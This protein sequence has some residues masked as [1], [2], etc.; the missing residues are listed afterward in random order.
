[1][2]QL[3]KE[4][5]D[6]LVKN[7]IIPEG[8]PPEQ[9]KFFAEVCQR[10]KLDPF[11]RQIHLIERRE[12]DQYGNWKKSYTIQAGIDGMRAIAQRN[13]KII[14]YRRWVEKRDDD[15][16]GCCEIVS[17]RGKYY[18]ELPFKEYVQTK[19]NGEP[20]IFWKKFP[21]T[22]IKKCAEESVLRMMTPEDLSGIYGDDE[23]MQADSE[24]PM[25]QIQLP[26]KELLPQ[27][28][29]LPPVDSEPVETEVKAPKKPNKDKAKKTAKKNEKDIGSEIENAKT[30]NEL[31]SI[32]ESLNEDER[33]IY[34]NKFT[35]RKEEIKTQLENKAKAKADNTILLKIRKATTVEELKKIWSELDEE[36][37]KI[38]IT[39]IT[40]QN[41]ILT[42]NEK[43]D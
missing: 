32:W 6:L 8:T 25:A 22:M 35:E 2:E 4:Q 24:M 26:K 40:E 20:V 27:K 5:I 14:S 38:Y 34:L 3:T 31:K 37:Q 36:H 13:A 18:D 16:Y 9:I 11:Q 41:L 1:M 10:K 28:A 39:P 33:V 19:A 29:E 17:D 43:N 7:K 21:Q 42:Q 23:M 12:K 15:L 30:L